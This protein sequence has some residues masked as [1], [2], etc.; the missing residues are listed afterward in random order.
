M[1]R[2]RPTR[3]QLTKALGTPDQQEATFQLPFKPGDGRELEALRSEKCSYSTIWLNK[4]NTH[5]ILEISEFL[6]VYMAVENRENME[7]WERERDG[8]ILNE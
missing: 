7:L 5:A 8:K 4:G 1:I 2:N 3:R 6:Q